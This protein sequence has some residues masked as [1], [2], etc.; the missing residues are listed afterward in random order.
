MQLLNGHV[1]WV[2]HFEEDGNS[3][4]LFCFRFIP[5]CQSAAVYVISLLSAWAA[6]LLAMDGH[7]STTLVN[8]N[9]PVSKHKAGGAAVISSQS[10]AWHWQWQNQII[11]KSFSL[12]TLCGLSF[13]FPF[14]VSLD[15]RIHSW[16]I[17]IYNK[18]TTQ[19]YRR[20]VG[21]TVKSNW[22]LCLPLFSMYFRG[23]ITGC[24]VTMFWAHLV[25]QINFYF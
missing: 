25:C 9:L 21:V 20:T 5:C 11:L 17:Y 10:A 14:I 23:F 7:N 2:Q 19:C 3:F 4:P 13:I 16:L 12:L 15:N 6:A 18:Y 24:Q 1:P 22:H 8:L